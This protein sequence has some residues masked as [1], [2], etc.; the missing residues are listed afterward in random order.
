M[1]DY[2]SDREYGSRPKVR[3]SINK[4]VW[5]ALQSLIEARIN[6][7][8]LAEAFPGDPCLDG[9]G[10]VSTDQDA[11][12]SRVRGDIPC[13]F[14]GYSD[15]LPDTPKI[16]DLV[17]FIARHIVNPIRLDWHVHRKH[18]HLEFDRAEGLRKFVDDINRIFSRNGL[19]YELTE[20]GIV[21]RTIPA[22]I[23][24]MMKRTHVRTGDNHLDGLL[25]TAIDRFLSPKPEGRQDALEKLWDAFERLKTVE[26]GKDK[27]EQANALIDRATSGDSPVFRLIVE[28]EFRALT[29]AGNELR[30]RHSEIGSEP[31]G[32]SGEKDYLFSRMFSLFWLVLK[33]TGRMS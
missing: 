22:P 1:T 3:E 15:S 4:N 18:Q 17:Q 11:L 7:A 27:R 26:A 29:D 21:K 33:A 8:S 25:E 6:D 14:D 16:L 5:D 9:N 12:W 32:D 19:A 10:I 13:L 20:S 28:K 2:F 23:A 24:E 31:V 30:I